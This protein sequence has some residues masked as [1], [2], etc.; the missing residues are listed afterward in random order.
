MELENF[1]KEN[2]ALIAHL[3]AEFRKKRTLILECEKLSATD[4]CIDLM[5]ELAVRLKVYTVE[6]LLEKVTKISAVVANKADEN[7]IVTIVRQSGGDLRL[8]IRH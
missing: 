1:L 3:R 8:D 6:G 2:E 5:A 7:G 4:E